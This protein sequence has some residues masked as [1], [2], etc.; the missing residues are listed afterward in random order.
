MLGKRASVIGCGKG[1]LARKP[2]ASMFWTGNCIVIRH[3]T[4]LAE[5]VLSTL[6]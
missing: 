1:R 6:L 2:L 4:K 3:S 5:K